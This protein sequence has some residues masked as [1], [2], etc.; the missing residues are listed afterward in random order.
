MDRLDLLPAQHRA[1]RLFLLDA[2]AGNARDF[3]GDAEAFLAIALPKL[4][5]VLHARL[6]DLEL[7]AELREPLAAAY[8]RN[9]MK[10]LRRAVELRRIDGALTAAGIPY[11][12]LKGPV[13]AATVYPDRPSRTMTDLDFLLH[14]RDLERATAVL[15]DAGYHTPP[16]FAGAPMAA[17]D[18]APIIHDDP[19]GPSIELHTM[20]DSLPDEREALAAMLPS[21]RRVPLG[22]GLEMPTLG[23][24]EFFAHVVMHVS[25]HNRFEGELRSLLDVALLLHAERELDWSALAD[26]WE[27]RGIL[28]WIVLTASL[29]HLLLGAPV[30][31]PLAARAV[32]DEALAI[33][34]EQLWIV[35]KNVVPPRITHV[36][37][38]AE[39]TPVHAAVPAHHAPVPKGMAGVQARVARG[40]ELVSHVLKAGARGGFRPRVLSREVELFRKR[41]RLVAVVEKTSAGD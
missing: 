7:P 14:E 9:A 33:A 37:A 36:V 15:G 40:I 8:R 31:P 12:V 30:P 17:G 25:K 13:L 4:R 28:E 16:Q 24:G 3:D 41:E 35:E 10:E 2:L 1:V 20:L 29:A 39:L 19:G 21:S 34:A 5:P 23:R 27:R 6:R 18:I 22:H 11:L 26:A 38:G 32:S